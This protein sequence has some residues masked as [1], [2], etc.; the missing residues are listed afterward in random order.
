MANEKKKQSNTFT[1]DDLLIVWKN[2]SANSIVE[3]NRKNFCYRIRIHQGNESIWLS[4]FQLFGSIFH[5]VALECDI[6]A[7]SI[8]VGAQILS[9]FFHR[10]YSLNLS[11]VCEQM[12]KVIYINAKRLTLSLKH[13]I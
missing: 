9:V 2:D 4:F 8:V 5:S 7:M 12:M 13:Q 6:Q 3:S 10:M 1:H 11:S